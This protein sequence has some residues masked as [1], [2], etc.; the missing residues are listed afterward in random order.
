MTSEGSPSD[1]IPGL[2]SLAAETVFNSVST[3][4]VADDGSLSKVKY[5]LSANMAAGV[6]HSVVHACCVVGALPDH[7][8]ARVLV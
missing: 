1:M 5:T 6:A 8:C 2:I 4:E 7:G 3:G